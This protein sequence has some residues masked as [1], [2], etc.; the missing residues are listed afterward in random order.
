MV[1]LIWSSY[2]AARFAEAAD[3]RRSALERNVSGLMLMLMLARVD[4][5]SPVEY[6]SESQRDRVREFAVPASEGR[7]VS[8]SRITQESGSHDHPIR[9]GAPGV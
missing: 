3:V 9:F 1:E 5:K 4:G 8:L 2:L 7:C 6:L